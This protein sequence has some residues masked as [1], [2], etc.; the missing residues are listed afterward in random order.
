MKNKEFYNDKL[1]EIALSGNQLAKVNNKL[2]TCTS[3]AC[4]D[5]DWNDLELICSEMRSIWGEEEYIE[6][7]ANPF[8]L[9]PGDIF[10]CV[11]HDGEVERTYFQANSNF[12]IRM[13]KFGNACKDESYMEKRAREIRLYNLLSNF[14][15]QVNEGWEPDWDDK[16]ENKWFAQ[17]NFLNQW[18][19][20][21]LNLMR[22][23]NMV[24]FKT[25]ELAQRAIDEIVIPFERGLPQSHWL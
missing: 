3:I 10:Y 11:D 14:A 19:P 21:F 5:C 9:Q 8:E 16:N 17:F 20:A 2:T 12:D 6:P 24:Y 22:Y 18:Q 13:V 23:P 15:Y 25:K 7:K 4:S 1:I